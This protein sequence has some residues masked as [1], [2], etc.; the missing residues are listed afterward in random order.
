MTAAKVLQPSCLFPDRKAF[1][2]FTIPLLCKVHYFT[3]RM[4]TAPPEII[5]QAIFFLGYPSARKGSWR[6]SLLSYQTQK[7]RH[8]GAVYTAPKKS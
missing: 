2:L 3:I 6:P 1:D 8:P 4:L 7:K 5:K